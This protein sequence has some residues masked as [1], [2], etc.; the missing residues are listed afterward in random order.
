MNAIQVLLKSF[1][2]KIDPSEVE[3]AWQKTKDAVPRLV[4][5]VEENNRRLTAIEKALQAVLM[6]LSEM[7]DAS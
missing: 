1:G 3:S 4:A 7:K 2:I 6:I 5:A